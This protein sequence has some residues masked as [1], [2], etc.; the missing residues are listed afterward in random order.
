MI[1]LYSVKLEAYFK[2]KW[3]FPYEIRYPDSTLVDDSHLPK[4]YGE[5]KFIPM[6][7]LLQRVFLFET[8]A[9][10]KKAEAA[11]DDVVDSGVAIKTKKRRKK[12]RRKKNARR[13]KV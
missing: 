7:E 9:D 5:C 12:R 13:G 4:L 2:W 11:L 10:K 6:F 3:M 8:K 1:N